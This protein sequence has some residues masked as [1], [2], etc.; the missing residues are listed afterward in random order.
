MALQY[1]VVMQVKAARRQWVMPTVALCAGLMLFGVGFRLTDEVIVVA[2]PFMAIAFLGGALVSRRAWA[3][4]LAMG[5]GT[6][7]SKVH[8]PPPYVPDARHLAQ[9]GAPK[10]L[11]LPLGLTGNP[12]AE[13]VATS[14]IFIAAPT[15]ASLMGWL[16]RTLVEAAEGF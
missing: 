8:A 7:L 3:W 6:L 4:G 10:P 14:F 12:F 16:L 11:P 1:K 9:Y 13:L 15:I 5:F 2:V